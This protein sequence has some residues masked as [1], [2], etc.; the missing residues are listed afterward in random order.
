M[1]LKF[2]RGV[3]IVSAFAACKTAKVQQSDSDVKLIGGEVAIPNAFP[4]AV[5]PVE[6]DCSGTMIS[7]RHLLTAGHCAMLEPNVPRPDGNTMTVKVH[8]GNAEVYVGI[9]AKRVHATWLASLVKY[10]ENGVDPDLLPDAAADDPASSDI[11]LYTFTENLPV[12]FATLAPTPA[13]GATL[14]VTG[15]GCEEEGG[16]MSGR[17]KYA[18]MNVLTKQPRKLLVEQVATA[19]VCRGDSGGGSYLLA[20][21]GS[22]QLQVV[23]VNSTTVAGVAINPSVVLV[24]LDV[25]NVKNWIKETLA[26]EPPVPLTLLKDTNGLMIHLD[27]LRALHEIHIAG[28][29]AMSRRTKFKAVFANEEMYM[30]PSRIYG[31]LPEPAVKRVIEALVAGPVATPVNDLLQSQLLIESTIN[32]SYLADLENIRYQQAVSAVQIKR[33]S[34]ERFFNSHGGL[35]TLP[36]EVRTRLIDK[37][38]TGNFDTNPAWQ[39]F[40]DELA[41]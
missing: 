39:I 28:G 19:N 1:L 12:T 35:A 23:S 21:A 15:N 16:Q 34:L 2:S 26:A 30:S 22:P 5:Y 13:V 31:F 29:T 25:P 38:V 10:Q 41:E 20:T 24:R 14:T 9:A 18:P 27:G 3:L 6:I 32:P 17:L 40:K 4:A 36:T 7:P 8:A 33:S 37:L 11:A